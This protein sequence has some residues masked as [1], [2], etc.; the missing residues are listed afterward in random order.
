MSQQKTQHTN[1]RDAKDISKM[2]QRQK[3]LQRLNQNPEI[4]Y[5]EA[6]NLYRVYKSKTLKANTEDPEFA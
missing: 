2:I 3:E 1:K 5:D 4:T 6:C